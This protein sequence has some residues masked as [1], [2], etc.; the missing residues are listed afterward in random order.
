MQRKAFLFGYSPSQLI[1]RTWRRMCS[2]IPL[3]ERSQTR[4]VM[5]QKW[6][7]KR[8]HSNHT[9]FRKNRKR[10]VL[11][12]ENY[13]DLITAVHKILN[14]GCESRNN[15]RCAV[16]VQ[17]LATQGNPC[18]IFFFTGDREKLTKVLQKPVAEAK[19]YSYEQF[20]RIWQVCE[21]LF[22]NHRTGTP[23]Q[24]E[25][26]RNC[27]AGCTSDSIECYYYL[28]DSFWKISNVK[29]KLSV[30]E[31]IC[32]ANWR[33]RTVFTRNATQDVANNLKELKRT[34]IQEANTS[35]QQRLKEFL[36]QDDKKSRTVSLF[37]YDL[38][39]LSSNDVLT[40]LIKLLLLRVRES[41][42]A[43]LECREIHET[44]WVF[45]ETFQIVNM[46]DE[47]VMI[48]KIGGIIGD[49]E[50]RRNWEKWKRRTSAVNTFILFLGKSKT[51]RSRRWKASNVYERPYRGYWSCI[52]GMTIPSYLSLEMHLQKN[53][54]PNKIS[55]LNGDFLSRSLRKG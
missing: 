10:S 8:K 17:V 7:H 55:E 40:F 47:I 27:R 13:G 42:A 36:M 25:N 16:V 32:V 14:E 30:R 2:Y 21:E 4:M 9:H 45:Q 15:D 28:R 41:R 11:R 29:I 6:R 5:F 54:L 51:K 24:S 52:Q 53:P 26:K 46:L 37:F 38:D 43:K 1:Q 31:N 3:K 12:A 18:Q 50:N 20:T 48:Q 39:I 22:W 34:C 19:S 33:W 44:I 49:Y 23:H 35:I